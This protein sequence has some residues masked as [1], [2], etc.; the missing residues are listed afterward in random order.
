MA[1]KAIRAIQDLLNSSLTPTMSWDLDGN[2]F[3]APGNLFPNQY[4]LDVEDDGEPVGWDLGSGMPSRIKGW[5]FG[6]SRPGKPRKD[7]VTRQTT[8]FVPIE[9]ASWKQDGP[10]ISGGR[11]RATD[12]RKPLPP[13]VEKVA[14]S[15]KGYEA[16]RYG[17]A[18]GISSNEGPTTPTGVRFFDLLTNQYPKLIVPESFPEGTVTWDLYMTKKNGGEGSLALQRKVPVAQLRKGGEYKLLGPWRNRGKPPANNS[19]GL[20]AAKRPILGRDVKQV[21]SRRDLRVGNWTPFV[22]VK[23]TRGPALLSPAGGTVRV[24]PRFPQDFVRQ[25]VQPSTP[26]MVASSGAGASA[27]ENLPEDPREIRPSG[28]LAGNEYLGEENDTEESRLIGLL[29][30]RRRELGIPDLIV[31]QVMNRAAYDYVTG[32]DEAEISVFT[33]EDDAEQALAYLTDPPLFDARYVAIGVAREREGDGYQWAVALSEPIHEPSYDATELVCQKVHADGTVTAHALDSS[34]GDDVRAAVSLSFN[35]VRNGAVTYTYAGSYS[36]NVDT[37]ARRWHAVGSASFLRASG[38]PSCA[39]S[40]GSLEGGIYARTYSTGKMILNSY[41][42]GLGTA[43]AN[44]ACCAHELGHCGGLDHTTTPSVLNTPI[45]TNSSTNHETPTSYDVSEIKRLWGTRT[46][47][48][49]SPGGGGTDPDPAAPTPTTTQNQ[50]NN[51]QIINHQF[52]SQNNTTGGNQPAPK[53]E[54]PPETPPAPDPAPVEYEW[55]PGAYK[56][57]SGILCGVPPIARR[58]DVD[59]TYWFLYEPPAGTAVWYRAYPRRGRLGKTGYFPGDTGPGIT[60]HGYPP[61]E[62]P[63]GL[64]V[65]LVEEE[66]PTEDL[67]ILEAPDPTNIPDLPVIAGEETPPAGLYFVTVTGVTETG[68]LTQESEPG[69]DANGAIGI[70]I[71][72]GETFRVIPVRTVNVLP[73]GEFS[74]LDAT[75][76]PEEWTLVNAGATQPGFFRVNKGALTLG[77]ASATTLA[78]SMPSRRISVDPSKPLTVAGTI[79][80]VRVASGLVRIALTQLDET[81]V[82]VGADYILYDLSQVGEARFAATFNTGG[83]TL[84][85]ATTSVRLR[86]QIAGATVNAEGYFKDLRILRYASDVRK[87]E[88]VDGVA[89]FSPSAETPVPGDAYAVVGPVPDP[90]GAVIVSEPPIEVV[91]FES[92]D[93]NPG[94]AQNLS[95]GLTAAVIPSPPGTGMNG[96][97]CWRVADTTTGTQVVAFR[98]KVHVHTGGAESFRFLMYV[99]GVMPAF[100]R[101]RVGSVRSGGGGAIADVLLSALGGLHLQIFDAAGGVLVDAQIASGMAAGVLAD[102]EIGVSGGGTK[103]GVVTAGVGLNGVQRSVAINY[104]SLDFSNRIPRL[105]RVGLLGETDLRAKCDLLFDQIAVTKNGDVLDREKP[106]PPLNYVPSPPDAPRRS[107]LSWAAR[108]P[109]IVGDTRVPPTYN[110]RAYRVTV[111]GTS[112]PT[113]PVFPVISG[114]SVLDNGNAVSVL[115]STAYAAGSTVLDPAGTTTLYY[116]CTTA[117]TTA[118]SALVYPTVEGQMVTDGTAVFTARRAAT[119]TEAG[120]SYRKTDPDGNLLRQLTVFLPTG[121]APSHAPATLPLLRRP[122]AVKPGLTYTTSL[123]SRWTVFGS[124]GDAPGIRVW[125]EGDDVQP[126]LAASVGAMTGTR[127]W[128][129]TGDEDG[130]ATFAVPDGYTRARYEAVLT[131]GYYLFQEP[132][133]TDGSYP[134]FA[135]RDARRG[136]ARATTGQITAILPTYP[137]AYDVGQDVGVFWSEFGVRLASDVDAVRDPND[138]VDVFFSTSNDGVVF[139][140]EVTD[141]GFILPAAFLRTR[142]VLTGD[143]RD[144][145]VLPSGG[146][147]LRTWSPTGVLL[148]RDGSHFPGVALIGNALYET[149]YPDTDVDSVGGHHQSTRLTEDISRIFDIP[150]TVS[151][152]AAVREIERLSLSE[153][154]I[155]EIPTAGDTVGGKAFLVRFREQVNFES[156]KLSPRIQDGR[157]V[158]YASASVDEAEVLEHSIL[159]GPRSFISAGA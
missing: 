149:S 98:E 75:G 66:P 63:Q 102:I 117:G 10:I 52:N 97:Y 156:K 7:A 68:A 91:T 31:S 50:I 143:G 23:N 96:A 112:A 87:Y 21:S 99:N 4:L 67:S 153:P 139:G 120:S 89:N 42:F 24:K 85:P 35:L 47:S 122:I 54:A 138:G 90:E 107:L 34:E 140:P 45:I 152:E 36:G 127:G 53:P 106:A 144:G 92:G 125:L 76:T 17:W 108:T 73:N 56:G 128:N 159:P 126:K 64:A 59:F 40:D 46:T 8:S 6:V 2:T 72:T 51:Q 25:E 13:L 109:Y 57:K 137:T 78:P 105:T 146:I 3:L 74:Q 115:R 131:D 20:G 41:Y 55:V 70:T 110:N 118:A 104:G 129:P 39:I 134:T 121:S 133:H 157:R 9:E 58:K 88:L 155:L 48:G 77:T 154:L 28:K 93:W 11:F 142:C 114:G 136:Y 60:I 83:L 150:I 18:W 49:G 113:A 30:E 12:S 44:T 22:Q 119:W 135:Q 103:N 132:L 26:A 141:P 82:Q 147:Y 27:A 38:S 14:S 86:P 145:P 5:H 100:G 79:G 148:R 116:E 1:L 80:A 37:A 19:S 84:N 71:V 130:Y 33:W 15:T 32:T 101:T 43:N 158:Y 16:G 151:T 111:A 65:S 69:R 61:E 29:N 123:F 62:E 94:W 124:G 81:G 95:P